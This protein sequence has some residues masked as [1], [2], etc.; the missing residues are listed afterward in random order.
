M[1]QGCDLQDTYQEFMWSNNYKNTVSQ[2]HMFLWETGYE[3][4]QKAN[5]KL[6]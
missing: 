5:K 3:W 1:K 4:F 2:F 6:K